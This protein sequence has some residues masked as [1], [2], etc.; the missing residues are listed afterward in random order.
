MLAPPKRGASAPT[1]RLCAAFN[2]LSLRLPKVTDRTA[3]RCGSNLSCVCP[4][5]LNLPSGLPLPWTF[6]ECSASKLKPMQGQKLIGRLGESAQPPGVSVRPGTSASGGENRSLPQSHTKGPTPRF[7]P[8]VTY[9]CHL[10]RR[11]GAQALTVADTGLCGSV[12]C[13]QVIIDR[14]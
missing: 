4:S 9:E 1:G 5:P 13:R 2:G 12:R 8:S 3:G 7:T 6:A 14:E 10:P 11:R